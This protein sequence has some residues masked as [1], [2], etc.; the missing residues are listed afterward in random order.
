MVSIS[1]NLFWEINQ[2]IKYIRKYNVHKFEEFFLMPTSSQI[3]KNVLF[4]YMIKNKYLTGNMDNF[5]ISP[6]SIEINNCFNRYDLKSI[7]LQKMIKNFIINS[8]PAWGRKIISGRKETFLFLNPDEKMCFTESNLMD[9]TDIAVVKWWDEIA[10]LYRDEIAIANNEIGRIGERLTIAY[11]K[12]RTGL[13]PTWIAIDSNKKGYD[14]ESKDGTTARYI[15]VKTSTQKID[16]A[17]FFLTNNEWN[18]AKSKD[19]YYFYL[20]NI[21]DE[22]RFLA[23]INSARMADFIPINQGNSEWIQVKISF[24]DFIDSFKELSNLIDY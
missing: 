22:K 15:E 5:D 21:Y 8:K 2:L 20:W 23:I 17:C 3:N 7:T 1:L 12:N 16:E 14:I 19:N 11:E 10:N 18:V 4:D 24:K 6:F 9:G 13:L